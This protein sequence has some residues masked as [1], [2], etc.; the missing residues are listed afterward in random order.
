[1]S[2]TISTEMMDQVNDVEAADSNEKSLYKI[3]GATALI[4]ALMYLIAL[5]VYVPAYSASPPPATVQEWFTLFQD[6]WLT[7]LFFLG[8]ADEE[9]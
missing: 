6:N 1:M 9:F 7:G 4:C 2:A 5:G 8:F 3:G